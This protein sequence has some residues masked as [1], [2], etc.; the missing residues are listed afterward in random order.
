VPRLCLNGRLHQ[1][2]QDI[3]PRRYVTALWPVVV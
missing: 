1:A 3:R 2:I